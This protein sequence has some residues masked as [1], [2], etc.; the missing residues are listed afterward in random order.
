MEAKPE[1]ENDYREGDSTTTKAP[2][3]SSPEQ[4]K[5]YSGITKL[6]NFLAPRRLELAMWVTRLL[7]IFFTLFVIIPLFGNPWLAF[8]RA[9]ILNGITSLLRLYQRLPRPYSLSKLFFAQLILEDSCHYL[10]YSIMFLYFS[11]VTFSIIPIMFISSLHVASF[12][13]QMI[14]SVKGRTSKFRG[15]GSFLYIWTGQTGRMLKTV[16]SAEVF[17]M[18]ILLLNCCRG[19]ISI[20]APFAY[21]RF[22]TLRYASKRNHYTRTVFY[23]M[24]ML[25]EKFIGGGSCPRIIAV[26]LK[27]GIKIAQLTFTYWEERQVPLSTLQPNFALSCEGGCI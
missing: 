24:R 2:P 25:L 27:T 1:Q 7:S 14:E 11:P 9:L 22:L 23:E 10:W 13:L 4:V 8:R 15:V 17:L 19:N 21:Y 16:A 18:G 3:K 5:N 20:I 12:T 26:V 6:R